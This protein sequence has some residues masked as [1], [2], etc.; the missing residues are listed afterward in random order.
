MSPAARFHAVL[1]AS[2]ASAMGCS[3]FASSTLDKAS[4]QPSQVDASGE[5][6][7]GAADA[8][9]GEGAASS[10]SS[11]SGS[12][13]GSSSGSQGDAAQT[14]AGSLS[15][16]AALAQLGQC[17]T[18][19]DFT[20]AQGQGGFSASDITRAATATYGSCITCHGQGDGGFFDNA[21]VMLT[22]Q[23]TTQSPY[24]LRWVSCTVDMQGNFN[25]FVP[26][27]DI[28]N[29]GS[30][31]AEAGVPC[32]PTYQLPMGLISAITA[33]ATDSITRWSGG[34]CSNPPAD[35]GPG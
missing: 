12:A 2:L 33:F 9:S 1:F 22:F 21:D 6:D 32:H 19:L 8:P 27:N 4:S 26:S 23:E 31:C 28:F 18:Y 15:C 16:A 3:F 7:Q 14:E 30:G 17:M 13:S 34:M 24:I 35:G 20:T 5:V 29:Q 11:S 25:G 10:S